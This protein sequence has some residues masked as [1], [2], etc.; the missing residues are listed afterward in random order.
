MNG[1][2]LFGEL[3]NLEA[4]IV[5]QERKLSNVG[6]FV[7]TVT[8]L[9]KGNTGRI[10]V[11]KDDQSGNFASYWLEPA[12]TIRNAQIGDK[13][14]YCYPAPNKG[15]YFASLTREV[16]GDFATEDWVLDQIEIAITA[17]DGIIKTWVEANFINPIELSSAL[18][19]YV[20][21]T[22]L[23]ATLSSYATQTYV[24]NA[25][26]AIPA[27]FRGITHLVNHTTAQNLTLEPN[28]KNARVTII[29]PTKPFPYPGATQDGSNPFTYQLNATNNASIAI[30]DT[31]RFI[32][33][34]SARIVMQAQDGIT[35]AGTLNGSFLLGMGSQQ[36]LKKTGSLTYSLTN[37]GMAA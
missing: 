27:S 36:E 6:I 35:L 34:T 12:K 32:I 37:I 18:G 30:N 17:Y 20:T 31:F 24:N 21:T 22:A 33:N 13:V 16:S 1:Q 11:R 2:T 19:S 4:T 9:E 14:L 7:G 29:H 25:I 15:I 10:R 8:H 23:A 28:W 3:I 26:A 5:E